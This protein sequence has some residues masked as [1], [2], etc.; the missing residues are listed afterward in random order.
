M[1]TGRVV[2]LW[3]YPVKS[4]AGEAIAVA[5][6]DPGRGIAGDRAF[7]VIDVETG[8]VPDAGAPS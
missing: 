4:M 3:R 8:T 7:A 1:Q 2:E 5:R 6:A